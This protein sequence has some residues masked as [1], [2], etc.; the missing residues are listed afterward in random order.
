MPILEYKETSGHLDAFWEWA[1]KQKAPRPYKGSTLM[2]THT[3]LHLPLGF[4][5]RLAGTILLL[6]ATFTIAFGDQLDGLGGPYAIGGNE[7]SDV[8]LAQAKVAEFDAFATA[9]WGH[10]KVTE[11]TFDLLQMSI[12]RN[13]SSGVPYAD[14]YQRYNYVVPEKKDAKDDLQILVATWLSKSKFDAICNITQHLP[15]PYDTL[16]TEDGVMV[17][18]FPEDPGLPL[19]KNQPS[20]SKWPPCVTEYFVHPGSSKYTGVLDANSKHFMLA[21]GLGKMLKN[22][23]ATNKRPGGPD[24]AEVRGHAWV[25]TK[26]LYAGEIIVDVKGC[27]Y[28]INQGS[29]TY[30]PKP[31]DNLE[32]LRKVA[33]VFE[34]R[35]DLPPSLFW[36]REGD[37]EHS[38]VRAWPIQKKNKHKSMV[39]LKEEPS[40]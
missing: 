40:K 4:F 31:G 18:F 35:L 27:N 30:K 39:C 29:G 37:G 28:F 17:N 24:L 13:A 19:D 9:K 12:Q 21:Q 32:L 3:P 26:V 7:Y 22:Y 20:L 2:K 34:E 16:E 23:T 25:Q 33:K 10:S 5:T 15:K 36:I 1:I 14:R 11:L 38:S 6:L 8:G